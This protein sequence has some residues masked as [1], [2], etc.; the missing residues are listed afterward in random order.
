[1]RTW[2]INPDDV[3]RAWWA[4]PLWPPAP[5][6]ALRD[7]LHFVAARLPENR[8]VPSALTRHGWRRLAASATVASVVGLVRLG[9]PSPTAVDAT[10]AFWFAVGTTALAATLVLLGRSI[11]SL[12]EATAAPK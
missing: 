11:R 3:V 9:A 5:L 6:V 4:V 1:V 10:S 12:A 8:R 2:P 7:T